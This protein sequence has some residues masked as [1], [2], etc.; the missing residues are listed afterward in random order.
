MTTTELIEKIGKARRPSRDLDASI[1]LAFGWQKVKSDGIVPEYGQ[2]ETGCRWR[3]PYKGRAYGLPPFTKEIDAAVR[4]CEKALPGWRWA[5]EKRSGGMTLAWVT[6]KDD[7]PSI[8]AMHKV[9][10]LSLV[11]AILKAKQVR[12]DSQA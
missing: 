4:L 7:S 6:E 12:E 1:A 8:P 2:D 3:P 10:V 11:L 9:P 5:V